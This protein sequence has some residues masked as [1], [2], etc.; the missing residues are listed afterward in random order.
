MSKS[1]GPISLQEFQECIDAPAGGAVKIIR[2]YD[3]EFGYGEER[4]NFRVYVTR[5]FITTISQ[6]AEKIIKAS[7]VQHAKAVA[8]SIP[9]YKW[10]W[11]DNSECSDVDDFQIDDAEE[12]DENDDD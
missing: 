3:P 11:R 10:D 6:F 5:E 9:Q 12:T 4:K 7:S 1:F 2:K 8:R